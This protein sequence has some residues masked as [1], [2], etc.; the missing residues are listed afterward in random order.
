MGDMTA[1]TVD[2]EAHAV[3]RDAFVDAGSELI[4]TKG[5]EQVSIQDVLTAVGASR[6]A[7]YHYFGSKTE[8]LDA[9]VERIVDAALASAGPVVDDP[10]L[11]AVA[12]LEGLFGGIAQW[13]TERSELMLA[14]ARVW[15]S[16]E[17]ALTR[18]KMWRH[19]TARFAPL[20]AEVIRQGDEEG[21]FS[22]ASPDETARVLV[23]I[24]HGMNDAAVAAVAARGDERPTRPEVEAMLAA[25]LDALERIL[26]VAPGTLRLVDDALLERWFA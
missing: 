11:D 9:V 2:T 10:S 5:Y 26:G 15:S 18:D 24:M 6:G 23:A 7:F 4:R 14:L 12:K 1:R 8:L 20:L 25:Y 13:K 21:V 19:V 22:V 17:N 16:D 3:R